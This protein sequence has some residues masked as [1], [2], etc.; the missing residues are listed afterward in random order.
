MQ[1][2]SPDRRERSTTTIDQTTHFGVRLPFLLV[3]HLIWR[4]GASMPQKWDFTPEETF[5]AQT[6][7]NGLIYAIIFQLVIRPTEL[8]LSGELRS[9]HGI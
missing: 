2:Y 7:Y 5:L 6:T 9:L 4:F 3:D 8:K 1:A